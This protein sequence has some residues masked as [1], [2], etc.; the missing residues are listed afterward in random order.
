MA[1]WHETG[2]A[3][4]RCETCGTTARVHY[5]FLGDDRE[6]REIRGALAVAHLLTATVTACSRRH[7]AEAFRQKGHT[8]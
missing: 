1:S 6:P 4:P 8:T 2:R 7:A 3:R 5:W